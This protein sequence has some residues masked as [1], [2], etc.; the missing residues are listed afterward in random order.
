MERFSLAGKVALITGGSRG[1]GRSTAK[2]FAK[3]GA[4]I[5]VAS[6][7]LPDLEKVSKEVKK[8]GRRSLAIAA[9]LGHIEEIENLI[10]R[11]REELGRIDIL[12]NNAAANPGMASALSV[13]DRAWD[14]IMNVNLKG[15]FFLSQAA[16][17]VMKEQGGGCIINVSSLAGTR[18]N[19]L[20]PV[21]S[22]SKA[23]VIMAT[24]IMA[25][26]W[27]KYNIRVNGI[28]PGIFKTQFSKALWS[29]PEILEKFLNSNHMGRIADT[30]EIVG[31]MIY[32]A[33]DA[34]SFITGI[35]IRV[36]GGQSI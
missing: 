6:R 22:I 16:A 23:G 20:L 29:D 11:A 3:A 18:P 8:M 5:V 26:E 10:S 17:R 21:Y 27:A 2:G 28:A 15:V 4:D 24:K 30:E 33:S 1:I 34:S 13:D 32:L 12:V 25:Q 35:T 14:S 19:L 9:H 31:T 36:D 7:K